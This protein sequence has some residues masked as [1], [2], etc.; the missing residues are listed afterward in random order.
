MGIG[1]W[2]QGRGFYTK[3]H[4]YVADSFSPRPRV[5]A[6]VSTTMFERNCVL[7]SLCIIDYQLPTP[8]KPF[9][10]ALGCGM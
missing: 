9:V 1:D 6:S 4:S 10:S 3:L 5:W 8:K 2:G 7:R